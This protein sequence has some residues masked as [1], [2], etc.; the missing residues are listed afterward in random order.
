MRDTP[1]RASRSLFSPGAPPMKRRRWQFHIGMLMLVIAL[2]A[3]P[4]A[5]FDWWTREEAET[6]R[7]PRPRESDFGPGAGAGHREASIDHE[8]VADSPVTEGALT[9]ASLLLQVPDADRSLARHD[10]RH[11]RQRRRHDARPRATVRRLFYEAIPLASPPA[12]QARAATCRGPDDPASRC[13]PDPGVRRVPAT[14]RRLTGLEAGCGEVITAELTD[15]PRDSV[16][17]GHR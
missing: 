13:D 7:H 9:D 12:L 10:D 11:N 6:A 3:I 16:F 17:A 5:F 1:P 14:A 2:L 15:V 4:L 8:A